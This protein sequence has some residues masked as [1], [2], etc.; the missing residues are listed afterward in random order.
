MLNFYAT[1]EA[2]KVNTRTDGMLKA[3][4]Y[5]QPYEVRSR[6]SDLGLVQ[7]ELNR[8]AEM[9][10]MARNESTDN[11]PISAGGLFS[12]IYGNRAIREILRPQGWEID[13]TDNIEATYNPKTGIKIIFQNV[14]VAAVVWRAPRAISGKGRGA[15][16]LVLNASGYLFPEYE[17][18]ER[19]RIET[20][21]RRLGSVWFLCVSVRE[22]EGEQELRAELSNPR[23]FEGGQFGEFNERIFILSGGG[24]DD[25]ADDER[26]DGPDEDFEIEISRK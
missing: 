11:D 20:L 12:Y 9:A 17:E 1:F 4:I 13:R 16:R 2:E 25:P 23:P 24:F 8:V 14:D 19:Q 5:E 7:G 3:K 10:L 22:I 15:E 6:L 18:E 21:S 26:V